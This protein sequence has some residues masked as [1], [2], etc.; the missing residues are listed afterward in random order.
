MNTNL[1]SIIK[2]T[3]GSIYYSCYKKF[4]PTGNRALIYH[5][6]GSKLKHDTYGIS[7]ELKKFR[8]H[9]WYLS[10]KYD[11]S[12]IGQE[13]SLPTISIT[14]DDGY[15]DSLDA[16]EVLVEKNIPFSI[17]ISTGFINKKKYMSS[18]DIHDISL[19]DNCIIGSHGHNHV[20]LRNISIQAQ[21]NELLDSKN[22]LEDII[23]NSINSLS[24]PHGSFDN[25]TID[26]AQD[27]GYQSAAS[28]IKGY[29]NKNTN[30]FIL[31]RSEIIASD[32]IN[33]LDKKIIGYYDFY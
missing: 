30:Q 5:A 33:D 22:S 2:D 11:F 10:Q 19:I 20:R 32:T 28:S 8:E 16:I 18:E 1:K 25:N 13:S 14:I 9:I 6:F 23:G 15:K 4:M 3:L 24:Y 17:Y 21:K 7:I 31:K 12:H 29:N 27:L 26:I